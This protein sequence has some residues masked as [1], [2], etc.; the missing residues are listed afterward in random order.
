MQ[1]SKALT[2]NLY[3]LLRDLADYAYEYFFLIFS[4]LWSSCHCLNCRNLQ[5]AICSYLEYADD[6]SFPLPEVKFVAEDGRMVL[7]AGQMPLP[8]VLPPNTSHTKCWRIANSGIK[9]VDQNF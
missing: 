3:Q 7:A 9:R 8:S 4:L 2:I 1:V 5:D 6:S